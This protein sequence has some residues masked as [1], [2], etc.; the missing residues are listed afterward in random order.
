MS[1]LLTRREY[2]FLACRNEAWRRLTWRMSIFNICRFPKDKEP[3]E[4]DITYNEEGEPMYW[5]VISDDNDTGTVAE[6]RKFADAKPNEELF[7]PEEELAVPQ[8]ELWGVDKDIISTP[9]RF[10]TNWIVLRFSFG[11]KLPYLVEGGSFMVY[12]K[13]IYTRC[14]KNEED[15]PENT[16][17]IRPSEVDRFMQSLYEV[18]PMCMAVVPTGT[19]RSLVTDPEVYRVRD[20]FLKD[21]A[22]RLD[23]PSVIVELIATLESIDKKWLSED[24]SIEFYSSK[25]AR[26]RRRKLLLIGGLE[27]AFREDGSYTLIAQSLAEETEL[28]H[29]VERFN[30]VREGSFSRGAETAKGGEQVRIIQMIFQ[31]HRIVPGDCGTKLTYPTVLNSY[32]RERYIGMNAVVDGKLTEVTPAFVEQNMGKMIKL[33]RPFLCQQ[34]H[35]DKCEACTSKRKPDEERAVGNDIAA[36]AS[37]IMLNAMGAMHGRDTVVAEYQPKLHI[38]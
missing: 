20:K 25:K 6:W 16:E 30:N 7:W 21:N 15:E 12:E 4:Y 32:N 5:A 34:G 37:H 27:T 38:T 10:V 23:D 14:L 8:S 11:T 9:G 28:T 22:D 13:E 36:G 19:L 2:L 31:N 17:A 29:A 3:R 24:Q 33:R 18:S 35:V 26:M 1:D